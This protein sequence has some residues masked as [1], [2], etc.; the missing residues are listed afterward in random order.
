MKAVIYSLEKPSNFYGPSI[1][2]ARLES[3]NMRIQ[4]EWRGAMPPRP[5]DIIDT[6]D[7]VK[8]RFRV[9]NA[10]GENICPRTCR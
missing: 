2:W 5:G 3:N 6:R 10:L 1:L 7:Y 9:M 8:E 4:I